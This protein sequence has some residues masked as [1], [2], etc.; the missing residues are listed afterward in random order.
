MLALYRAGRQVDALAAY[1][2]A[3]RAFVEGL[4]IEPS[5]DLRT[6]EAAILRHDVPEPAPSPLAR[7]PP[8]VGPDAR[9]WVTCVVTQLGEVS[10]LDPESLRAVVEPL[11]ARARA[12]AE[13][14]EGTVVALHGDVIV[15]MFGIPAA[16]EDDAL[17][18][19]RAAA[20]LRRARRGA[21]PEKSWPAPGR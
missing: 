21:P 12:V 8:P 5:P 14:H 19:V 6:L 10:A 13:R 3:R 16:H 7:R 4:G 1:R 18:A 9:R 15:T 20:E 11:H 2:D 17:R